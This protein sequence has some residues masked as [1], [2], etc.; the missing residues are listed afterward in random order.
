[1]KNRQITENQMKMIKIKLL[2]VILCAC[3]HLQ[4]QALKTSAAYGYDANGN[5]ISASVIYLQTTLKSAVLPLDQVVPND[6]VMT[7][8]SANIPK[9]GWNPNVTEPLGNID[10]KVYPNPTSEMIIIEF[11]GV[12]EK[13]L[14]VEGNNLSVFDMQGR[15]VMTNSTLKNYNLVNFSKMPNGNYLLKLSIGGM[16]KEYQI[17]KQ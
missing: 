15:K 7:T 1:V 16:T 11:S 5:R 10:I 17:I 6:S 3:A 9:Q 13:Q 8:D 12:T 4:A 2:I 14:S